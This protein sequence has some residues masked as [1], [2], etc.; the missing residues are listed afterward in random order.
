MTLGAD[1]PARH[2]SN[3]LTLFR[4]TLQRIGYTEEAISKLLGLRV[5][6]TPGTRN[7]PYYLRRL[8]LDDHL[9]TV[10]RLFFLGVSESLAAVDT[11]LAPMSVA[12]LQ[13]MGIATAEDDRV[14]AEIRLI[15]YD[16]L[17]VASDR[18][19]SRDYVLGVDP[20]SIQLANLTVRRPQRSTLDLGT[21]C[22][23]QALL[24][25]RHSDHVIAVDIDRRALEFAAFNAELNGMNN[26]ECRYGDLF[27]SVEG[28]SFDLIVSQPPFIISPE[29]EYVFRD[30]GPDPALCREIVHRTPSFLREGGFASVIA[31]WPRR[32]TERL[33]EPV[34]A[35]IDMESA[36]H[37]LLHSSSDDPL[38]YAAFL[39]SDKR[40]DPSLFD[41]TLERWTTY[42]KRSAIESIEFG[43]VVMRKRDRGKTVLLCESA[44]EHHGF[45]SGDQMARLLDNARLHPEEGEESLLRARFRLAGAI[46]ANVHLD[47]GSEDERWGGRVRLADGAGISVRVA[48]AFLRVL[49]LLDGHRTLRQAALEAGFNLD[50]G[51]DA[52][53]VILE[54][55]RS[56]LRKGLLDR[57]TPQFGY[58]ESA[59]YVPVLESQNGDGEHD[60]DHG[61]Q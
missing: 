60:D 12:Q 9:S 38:T 57:A 18:A 44:P 11:A 41:Q 61:N 58:A 24:A 10:I 5:T 2:G 28:L 47:P 42:F 54:T 36:D 23:I 25:A 49:P 16:G 13:S 48:G 39:N 37:V 35:W 50:T 31:S 43:A 14:W 26:I 52:H 6:V 45:R 59:R 40:S 32:D 7:M 55:V 21:G 1:G 17:F 29:A 22:G 30:S 19:L 15:P 56:L 46:Q 51:S 8:P 34:R 53:D 4:S 3:S 27:D 20:I 33:F